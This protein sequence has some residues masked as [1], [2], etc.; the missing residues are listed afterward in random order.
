M[1]LL[2]SS[3]N[4][5]SVVKVCMQSILSALAKNRLTKPGTPIR[6]TRIVMNTIP[7]ALAENRLTK[8]GTPIRA[9]RI[10]MNTIPSAL[11]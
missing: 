4:T 1:Q 6:A 10:V 2:G 3:E 9:T 11:A 8:P 5:R 7:N